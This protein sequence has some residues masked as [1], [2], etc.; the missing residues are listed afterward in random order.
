MECKKSFF[1]FS[2]HFL[3]NEKELLTANTDEMIYIYVIRAYKL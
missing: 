2:I 3:S 1:F